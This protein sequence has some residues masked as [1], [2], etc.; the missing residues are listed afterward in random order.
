LQIDPPVGA[1]QSNRPREI[2]ATPRHNCLAEQSSASVA[3]AKD[4]WAFFVR[5]NAGLILMP[6][7]NKQS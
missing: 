6:Q 1:A 3:Y 5:M 4:M 7:T 2:L